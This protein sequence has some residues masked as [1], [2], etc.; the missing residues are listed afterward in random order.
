MPEP[1]SGM[2]TRTWS[3]GDP[4]GFSQFVAHAKGTLRAGPHRQLVAVPLRDG[5]ARLERN[6]R[7]VGNGVGL[8]QTMCSRSEGLIQ[9]AGVIAVTVSSRILPLGGILLQV[10][11]QVFARRLRL[12]LPVGMDGLKRGCGRGGRGRGDTHEVTVADCDGAHPLSFR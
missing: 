4:K 3:C 9:V 2:S 6:V 5:G 7:D 8:L 1:V 10:I 11:E 12:G